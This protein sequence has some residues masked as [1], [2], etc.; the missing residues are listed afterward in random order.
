MKHVDNN[1][2]NCVEELEKN[3]IHIDGKPE[4]VSRLTEIYSWQSGF[5][6]LVNNGE[7]I[8]ISIKAEPTLLEKISAILLKYGFH[9]NYAISCA[10]KICGVA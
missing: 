3:G 10:K 6:C 5:V 9:K 8:N 4:L 1:S 7:R 2:Q